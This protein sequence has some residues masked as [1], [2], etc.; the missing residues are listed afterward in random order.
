MIER[1][2][3]SETEEVA[4]LAYDRLLLCLGGDRGK[5]K[6]PDGQH[7]PISASELRSQLHARRKSKLTSVFR[8]VSAEPNNRWRAEIF[9][10]GRRHRLGEWT[11]ESAAAETY[12]RAALFLRGPAA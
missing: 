4:A 6:F 10:E 11:E 2:S 7:D 9:A 1:A 3:G 12:D 8:G 5:L